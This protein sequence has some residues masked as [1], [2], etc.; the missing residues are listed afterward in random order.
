[1]KKIELYERK[2]EKFRGFIQHAGEIC[3]I[4]EINL[5]IFAIKFYKKIT[6]KAIFM[7]RIQIF[8]N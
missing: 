1:M 6:S 4:S 2:R 3:W 5:K 7:I 8:N